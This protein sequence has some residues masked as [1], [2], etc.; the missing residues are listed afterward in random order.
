MPFFP[1]STLQLI[2][3][4]KFNHFLQCNRIHPRDCY[5]QQ[6]S[7]L[8]LHTISSS[9]DA[10]TVVISLMYPLHSTRNSM[11]SSSAFLFPYRH[12]INSIACKKFIVGGVL[13]LQ[14][15]KRYGMTRYFRYL[16]YRNSFYAFFHAFLLSHI[17]IIINYNDGTNSFFLLR[18]VE[19]ILSI[20]IKI[21]HF[22][23]ESTRKEREEK[24]RFRCF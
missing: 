21:T 24:I 2:S 5:Q 18:R 23:G 8:P 14:N 12:H 17:A 22:C 1:S 7:F 13:N 15:V 20:P 9:I 16:F 6:G 4:Q 10:E 11:T 3:C 19:Q